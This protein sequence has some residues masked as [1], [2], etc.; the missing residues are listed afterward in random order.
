MLSAMLSRI[1][2]LILVTLLSS[3][4]AKAAELEVAEILKR[5]ASSFHVQNRQADYTLRL[6]DAQGAPDGTRKVRVWIKKKSDAEYRL[7]I[8]ALEPAGFR[9]IALLA[10]YQK[11]SVDQWLYIPAYRKVRRVSGSGGEASFLGSEFTLDDVSFAR[12]RNF[13]WV[14]KGEEACGSRKCLIIEG[15]RE[16]PAGESGVARR[17]SWVDAE[18]F[19]VVKSDLYDRDHKRVRVF[20]S[21]GKKYTMKNLVS[22]RSSQIEVEVSQSSGEIPDS[23]FLP[24]A[25][26]R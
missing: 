23:I 10:H 3:S 21:E 9:G 1:A 18:S 25:L 13:T 7:L 22:G 8:R 4:H 12:E 19:Q 17:V 5:A 16:L 24:S 20:T 14:R 15:N 11:S 26:E 6:F 2:V